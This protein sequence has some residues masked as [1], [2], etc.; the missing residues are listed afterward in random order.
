MKKE[1]DTTSGA[2]TQRFGSVPGQGKYSLHPADV[3][4]PCPPK[5][6]H[7]SHTF[8][9]SA[10]PSWAEAQVEGLQAACILCE[11]LL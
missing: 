11:Q 10:L 1:V 6:R 8:L 2:V 5:V 4:K 7:D 3:P 9:V